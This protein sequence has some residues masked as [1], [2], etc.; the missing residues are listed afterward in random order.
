MAEVIKLPVSEDRKRP[1]K[2]SRPESDTFDPEKE[3]KLRQQNV[4]R[5]AVLGEED[6]SVKRLE[7]LVFGAEDELLERLV[8]EV[9]FPPDSVQKSLI[10]MF[11]CSHSFKPPRFTAQSQTVT[12][13]TASALL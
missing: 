12:L 8:E 1:K 7:T 5:L 3:E 13:I 10:L 2:R 11:N 4:R 6:V 9:M